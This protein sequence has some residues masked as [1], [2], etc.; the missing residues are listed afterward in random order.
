MSLYS[1]VYAQDYLGRR[2][3]E[4]RLRRE[5]TEHLDEQSAFDRT[6][7]IKEFKESKAGA[8]MTKDFRAY[9]MAKPL[10]LYEEYNHKKNVRETLELQVFNKLEVS[11]HK[12]RTDLARERKRLD[13]LH[14]N[15]R[16]ERV[17]KLAAKFGDEKEVCGH[18]ER[19]IAMTKKLAD[20]A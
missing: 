13:I 15:L 18:W 12:M 8:L 14:S 19:Q 10:D 7:K 17:D 1:H 5:I 11:Q 2:D 6:R 20:L 16:Q 4:A 9:P 3:K